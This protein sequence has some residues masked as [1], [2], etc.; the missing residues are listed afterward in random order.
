MTQVPDPNSGVKTAYIKQT[1][2]KYYPLSDCK[3][4]VRFE[5]GEARGSRHQQLN[6]IHF[7]RR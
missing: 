5:K 2:D 6:A 4:G 3:Q 7:D 1:G